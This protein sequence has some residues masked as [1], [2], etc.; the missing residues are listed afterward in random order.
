MNELE[1]I[2]KLMP[3]SIKEAIYRNEESKI[4]AIMTGLDTRDF[5]L[6]KVAAYIGA[7][8]A[9]RRAKWASV[10]SGIIALG[11]LEK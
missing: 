5:S 4:A 9:A 10:C 7:R 8:C 1:V 3:T 2:G 11:R 6:D